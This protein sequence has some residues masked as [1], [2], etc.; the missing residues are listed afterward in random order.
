MVTKYSININLHFTTEADRDVVYTK[1]KT[2]LGTFK[3]TNGWDDGTMTK[4][5]FTQPVTAQD[6]V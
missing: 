4:T 2:A 5:E 6:T 3:G 1:I